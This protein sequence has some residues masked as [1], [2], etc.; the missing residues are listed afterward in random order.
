MTY[1]TL[2]TNLEEFFFSSKDEE[3]SRN[4]IEDRYYINGNGYG[5]G[6]GTVFGG[7]DLYSMGYG[8]GARFG[9]N[10][11]DGGLSGSGKYSV[12]PI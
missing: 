2:S 7:G 1:S 12:Y 5:Y 8:N 3:V 6:E 9:Y 11:G 10:N 4:K